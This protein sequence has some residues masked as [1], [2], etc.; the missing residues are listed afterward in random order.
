MN[1]LTFDIEEWFHIGFRPGMD[2]WDNYEVRIHKNMDRILETLHRHNRKGTFFVLG[3]IAEKY[4]EVVKQIMGGGHE[5][6]C[7]SMNH[8][9]VT[10][11]TPA[12]FKEDTHRALSVIE[13]ICGYKITAYRAPGFSITPQ[14]AW[15][16]EVLLELGI[17][18]DASVFPAYHSHGGYRSFGA[19]RPVNLIVNGGVIKEFP[20]N[21]QVFHKHGIVFSGGGYFR[22]FPYPLIKKWTKASP[23]VMAYFHPRDFDGAQPMLKNFPVSQKFKSYY[24]LNGAHRKLDKWLTDFETVAMFE[25]SAGIDWENVESVVV[26]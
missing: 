22:L 7:H 19:A 8:Q 12:S 13:D 11:L 9:L 25:A 1:I 24:G 10:T 5:L 2:G 20:L 14:S 15:A 21:T 4:P 23:Y 17:T 3:W 6:G 16:F 26:G 18:H